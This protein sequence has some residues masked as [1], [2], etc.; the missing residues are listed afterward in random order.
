MPDTTPTQV[1]HNGDP[2]GS[3]HAAEQAQEDQGGSSGPPAPR[4]HADLLARHSA[5]GRK[6]LFDS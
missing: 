4:S 5:P 2:Q 6:P 3:E 1:P